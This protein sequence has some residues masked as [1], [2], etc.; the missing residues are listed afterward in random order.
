MKPHHGLTKAH[1]PPKY[2]PVGNLREVG[3]HWGLHH[4]KMQ[5]KIKEGGS[6]STHQECDRKDVEVKRFH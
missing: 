2:G 5:F 1:K 4:V 3:E 6:K